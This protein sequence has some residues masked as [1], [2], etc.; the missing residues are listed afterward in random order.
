MNKS[1]YDFVIKN[2]VASNPL[3]S[4]FSVVVD[5]MHGDADH[6]TTETFNF[7]VEDEAD[8]DDIRLSLQD[9]IYIIREWSNIDW[10]TRCDLLQSGL[11][12]WLTSIGYP[13]SD[14][15]YDLF[16]SDVSNYDSHAHI[17]GCNV[18]WF[19]ENS[20]KYNVDI[21]DIETNEEI[22]IYQG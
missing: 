7:P 11:H 12:K 2:P 17:N 9:I 13:N 16:P 6:Y 8:N 21:I 20:I 4:T 1:K 18:Y 14:I 5:Y 3:C 15:I 22:K 10:N 19:D